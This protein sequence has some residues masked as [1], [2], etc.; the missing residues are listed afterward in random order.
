MT[1]YFK[2]SLKGQ[3]D[4]LLGSPADGVGFG[5]AT[6]T[7]QG[8]TNPR[9][10]PLGLQPDSPNNYVSGR[11]AGANDIP[12]TYEV[13]FKLKLPASGSTLIY[14]D[15]TLGHVF[16][17]GVPWGFRIGTQDHQLQI[18]LWVERMF[19][20]AGRVLNDTM[21]HPGANTYD[22]R[23]KKSPTSLVLRFDYDPQNPDTSFFDFTLATAIPG[24]FTDFMLDLP[25]NGNTTVSDF[26]IGSVEAALPFW[27]PIRN[28]VE[29]A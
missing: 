13:T 19:N 27:S 12:D 24:G 6:W 15:A 4:P 17:A 25:N 14:L 9:R 8:G 20:N 22:V 7:V 16:G 2:D 3:N 11:Y 26:Q 18:M 5:A 10:T 28:T 29:R 1:I 23:L 21:F